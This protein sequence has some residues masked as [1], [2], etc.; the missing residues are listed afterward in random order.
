VS[1]E[2]SVLNDTGSWQADDSKL[3]LYAGHTA[4][5][6]GQLENEIAEGRWMLL[7]ERSDLVFASE[8]LDLWQQAMSADGEV[9]VRAG[10]PV[11][12]N[13]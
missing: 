12:A 11:A 7:P 3:R 6:P 10:Q 8:P 13:D 1:G 5:E 2:P 4:W 9:V